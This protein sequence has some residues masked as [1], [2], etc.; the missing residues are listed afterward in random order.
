MEQLKDVFAA[1]LIALRTGAGMTQAQLAEKLNYSDKSVSKWERAD[2]MPDL[3]VA[4]TIAD[5][6]GVTVDY[7][8]TSHDAWH[9]KPAKFHYSLSTITGVSVVGVWVIAVLLFLILHWSMDKMVWLV[10]IAAVPASLLTL[11]VLNS[12]WRKERYH[13]LVVSALVL[14]VFTLVG[15][16]LHTYT[17]IK[18]MW[19]LVF[20]WIPAQLVVFL[21]FRIRR[22]KK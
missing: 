13:L 3:A 19:A 9:G 2:A 8:L 4:K 1:N 14:S 5:E 6:F 10:F 22:N 18:D 12:V 20:L 11:L 17:P 21:S 15:Y 7:L 16:I